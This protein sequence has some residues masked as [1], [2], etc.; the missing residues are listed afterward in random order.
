MKQFNLILACAILFW[1]NFSFAQTNPDI[2]SYVKFLNN[3]TTSAKEYILGLFKTHDIVVICE[4][5]HREF[6]QYDLL[7]N[8]IEDK[9]FINEAGNVFTELGVSNLNPALNSFLHTMNLPEQEQQR[10]ILTFHRNMDP[11]VL[12][13]KYSYTYL[14]QNL[15]NLNNK[16]PIEDAISLYPSNIPLDWSKVDSSNYKQIVLPLLR[17]RDS[18]VAAQV[19][20]QFDE[21]N[22]S[23]TKHKKALVIMNYRHAFNKEFAVKS[24]QKI[25]NV[26]EY[27]F[28]RYGNR[29]ANV[30]LYG[31]AYDEK[32]NSVLLQKGKWDAAFKVTGNKSIGFNFINTP[33][34]KD[35]FDL[36]L[37]Q[38]PYS[39]QDVFTGFIFYKPIE[40][41]KL[42]TGIPGFLDSSFI[43]EF[44]R[45]YQLCSMVFPNVRH[46]S[47]EEIAN[48]KRDPSG[49]QKDINTK[50][51]QSYPEIDSLLKIRDQWL[52]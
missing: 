36:W 2:S 27:L 30:Y 52:K 24:G 49:W 23:S 18:I 41:Q 34:G 28:K 48:F 6:T 20:E 47:Q 25:S 4:R 11:T 45:R 43:D 26:T 46:F 38:N 50:R 16:L 21:I 12:W 1:T 3:Q 29:V 5:D 51:E 8:I 17:S 32:E 44:F 22:R 19:I 39:Y 37:F 10:Q 40:D 42:V 13:E 15:Y 31:L 35:S 9:R 7:L 33:F 14:L